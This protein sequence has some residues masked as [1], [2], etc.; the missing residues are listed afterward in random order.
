MIRFRFYLSGISLSVLLSGCTPINTIPREMP[1][2]LAVQSVP[3]TAEASSYTDETP[4]LTQANNQPAETRLC[5]AEYCR[6]PAETLFDISN[7]PPVEDQIYAEKTMED[8][9]SE[10]YIETQTETGSLENSNEDSSAL[11]D[12]YEINVINTLPGPPR[13]FRQS[14]EGYWI[15]AR[16]S[17]EQLK[18]LH[19]KNIQLIITASRMKQSEIDQMKADV[20]TAGMKQL[21]IPFGSKF[22]R[23]SL[24]MDTIKQY[25]PSEIYIHCDHGAD[26]S[27][28]IL[29]YLLYAEQGYTI[30]NAIAAV[31]SPDDPN[32]QCLTIVLNDHE[33]KFSR[34]H[35]HQVIG[36]YS[37][38]KNNGFGGLKCDETGYRKLID[39]L[40]ATMQSQQPR[41]K[42]RSSRR[43]STHH[44]MESNVS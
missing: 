18:Y 29:A 21:H 34:K 9:Q 3:K 28:A 26:R 44:T 27:G 40:I 15:G 24:F 16:P 35:Y 14:A 25:K 6:T 5:N 8:I 1:E 22:P 36:I 13:N 43:R 38:E 23:P 7:N 33:L 12:N 32:I 30:Q 39:S 2:E 10:L 11:P 42:R 31:A 4:A 37:G 20:E 41:H 17:I 19:D